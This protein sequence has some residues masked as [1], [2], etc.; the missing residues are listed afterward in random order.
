M[1]MPHY[2]KRKAGSWE[3]A[4]KSTGKKKKKSWKSQ[5]NL[6]VRKS[7]NHDCSQS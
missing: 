4:E 6:T 1:W 2:L 7:G 5:V 3:F